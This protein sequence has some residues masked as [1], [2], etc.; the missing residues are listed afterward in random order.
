MEY[1]KRAYRFHTES[2]KMYKSR[3][4]MTKSFLSEIIEPYGYIKSLSLNKYFIS[5]RLI[6][7]S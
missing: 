7:N 1:T 2:E 3:I 6:K 4:V 5:I